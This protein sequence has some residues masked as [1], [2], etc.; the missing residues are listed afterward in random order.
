[1]KAS[2][3]LVVALLLSAATATAQQVET[4]PIDQATVRIYGASGVER[5][6]L[7]PWT[8]YEPRLSY[9]S[10]VLIQPDLI[11][12]AAHVV[13]D[14]DVVQVR[15]VGE[16]HS[17][18]G[19]VA[20]IDEDHDVALVRVAAVNYPPIAIPNPLPTLSPGEMLH[21][22]GYPLALGENHPSAASGSLSRMTNGGW[23]EIAAALNPGNSGG[24]VVNQAGQLIGVVSARG[25]MDRG[26]QGIAFA[27]PISHIVDLLPHVSTEAA[28][29][30]GEFAWLVDD[31]APSPEADLA[32]SPVLAALIAHR[33][34]RL[35]V[36]RMMEFRT[37]SLA[38]LP[39]AARTEVENRLALARRALERAA[40]DGELT[41]RYRLEELRAQLDG[42]AGS[43]AV[44]A[45][46]TPGSVDRLEVRVRGREWHG[47]G[48]GG[49]SDQL[50][51]PSR[52]ALELGLEMGV[53]GIALGGQ[54]SLRAAFYQSR[55]VDLF[56][57]ITLFGD[58]WFNPCCDRSDTG[59]VGGTLAIGGRVHFSRVFAE[60]SYGPTVGYALEKIRIVYARFG[61]GVGYRLPAVDLGVSFRFDKLGTAE[62][63]SGAR[64][65]VTFTGVA[66]VAAIPL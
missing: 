33:E 2:A 59:Y 37:S 10:G 35:A 30:A 4:R 5:R 50:E 32:A 56:G 49:G 47:G 20:A 7:P 36:Q 55:H 52:F 31:G 51:D 21:I 46:S 13:K 53:V 60:V 24:P 39:P 1:M 26:I 43:G 64:S 61:A 25:R 48:D 66:F 34:W 42:A 6:T 18:T 65:D 9:G 8:A 57:R 40:S 29:P 27:S 11:A 62:D 45:T 41:E 58:W 22:T 63:W 19:A 15:F 16:N 17:R 12:T 44:A 14:L 23:L 38:S 3:P 54:V 28:P